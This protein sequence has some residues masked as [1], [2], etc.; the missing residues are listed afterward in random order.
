MIITPATIR[1]MTTPIRRT[2]IQDTRTPSIP[3]ATA[4]SPGSAPASV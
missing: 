3:P 4:N 2:H 1:S